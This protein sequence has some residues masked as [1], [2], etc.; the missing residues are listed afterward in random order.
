MAEPKIYD[1][2]G[3]DWYNDSL[4]GIEVPVHPGQ[5]MRGFFALRN[6]KGTVPVPLAYWYD[7]EELRCKIG[8]T[9][10]AYG[11]DKWLSVARHTIPHAIYEAVRKGG[12]WPAEIL[13]T[14]ESGEVQSSMTNVD[15]RGHNSGDAEKDFRELTGNIQEW[16][17][18]A[19]ALKK[20]GQPNNQTEAD[21]ISDVATKLVDLTNEA[22]KKRLAEGDPL[23]EELANIN[24]RWGTYIKP[25]VTLAA[26]L[27]TIVHV[28]IK[29]ENAKRAE[30][31]RIANEKAAAAGATEPVVV[32]VKVSAGTRKAVTSVN[33]RVVEITDIKKLSAFL[34][35]MQTP[36]ADFIEACTN[37]AYRLLNASVEVPGA[38]MNNKESAR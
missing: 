15:M 14:L 6:S 37:A 16:M 30:E 20:V 5:P 23:R 1:K 36:P 27:K 24:T 17:E 3:W 25:G 13:V 12:A 26:D 11:H 32:P 22:D 19:K 10:V 18:R 33:R 2:N 34:A 7:G 9:N 4:A 35:A 29:A 28:W 8:D 31:A 38:K 21:S